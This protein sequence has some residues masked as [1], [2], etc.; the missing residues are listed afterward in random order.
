MTV[1]AVDAAGNQNS[2][3]IPVTVTAGAGG[4]SGCGCA[5]TSTPGAGAAWGAFLMLGALVR[6]RRRRA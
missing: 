4:G 3:A 1:T 5:S 6:L 2:C